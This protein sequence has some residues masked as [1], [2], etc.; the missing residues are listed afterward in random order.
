M[1]PQ[2]KDNYNQEQ[3]WVYDMAEK[4]YR[5]QSQVTLPVGLKWREYEF[6]EA[7]IP[8][9]FTLYSFPPFMNMGG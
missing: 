9:F 1:K 7:W 6:A 4:T 3:A 5:I 2:N 8:D